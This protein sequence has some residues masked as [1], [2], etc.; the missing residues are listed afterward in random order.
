VSDEGQG[1]YIVRNEQDQPLELHL[2]SGVVLLAPG[3][4]I[5]LPE[6]DLATPQLQVLRRTRLVSTHQPAAT[7]ADADTASK[8]ESPAG[9]TR[10]A[11]RRGTTRSSV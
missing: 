4:S 2:P 1:R 5:E 9:G 7:D 10:P 3:Q 8:M 6:A 11:G